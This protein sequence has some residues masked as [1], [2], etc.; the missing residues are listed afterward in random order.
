MNYQILNYKYKECS[1]VDEKIRKRPSE[2]T[3]ESKNKKKKSYKVSELRC[4]FKGQSERS[5][6]WFKIYSKCMEEKFITR[7][8]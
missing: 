2:S 5:Q 3:G 8:P 4:L 6:H 1:S 7:E